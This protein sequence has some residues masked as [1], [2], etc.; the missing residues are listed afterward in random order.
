MSFAD[1]F[2]YTR[3]APART[4]IERDSDA[5]RVVL[6]NAV[7]GGGKSSLAAYRK[8]CEHT[9]QLPDANIWS[10][11]YADDAARGILDQMSWMDVY[12]ALE[13]E[14]SELRGP[15]R[16][17]LQQA[18]NQALSR[19]GIA[20]EMRDGQFEFY[21]PVANEFETRRDEDKRSRH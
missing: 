5:L 15:A 10:D 2:G 7:G 1:R 20:Y 18:A 21:E 9:Q 19:S 4:Q 16:S 6:W 8:L 17:E 3:P 14:F 11:S 13:G 12:E